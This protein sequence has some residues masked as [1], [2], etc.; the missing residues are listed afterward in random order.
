[1]ANRL[2]IM[3]HNNLLPKEYSDILMEKEEKKF[4]NKLN[5][6]LTKK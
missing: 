4:L 3:H 2:N 6:M 1:M 5:T